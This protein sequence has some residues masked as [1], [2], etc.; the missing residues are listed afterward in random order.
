MDEKIYYGEQLKAETLADA[1][2]AE[3]DHAGWKA[4][5]IRQKEEI[6]VQI[7]RRP[8]VRRGG[9][10]ALTVRLRQLPNGVMV[11]IGQ[12]V[13]LD[14]A[15]SMGV[16]ILSVLRNPWNL[17][18]RLDDLAQDLESLQLRDRVWQVIE[19]TAQMVGASHN[20]AET[21]SNVICAYCG[22]PNEEEASHCLACGA[23][24]QLNLPQT[25]PHCGFLV[26]AA[27]ALC[28]NCHRLAR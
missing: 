4:Q 19:S 11:Q 13:W 21:L 22:T 6:A 17:L 3:F 1:L 5:K 26:P 2:L 23:P 7:A 10:T 20:L 18:H 14:L 28:P 25:C 8:Q 12:Q 9:A 27:E 16:T 15:A 24:L